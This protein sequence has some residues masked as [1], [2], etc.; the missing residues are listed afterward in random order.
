MKNIQSF[1]ILIIAFGL[2]LNCDNKT[3]KN[4]NSTE[5]AS[6][7]KDRNIF[8]HYISRGLTKTSENLVPGYIMFPVPNSASTYLINRS[9]EVVHEWKGNYESFQAYLMD[10][11]SIIQ[12]AQDPDYPTFGFGGPYGRIQKLTWDNKMLWD[13]EYATKDQIIHHDFAIL[14]N[15]N[16]LAIAYET[17]SYNDAI[18]N[19]RKPELI[20]ESGPWLEKI[21]EI[22]PQGQS[23]GKIVWEWHVADHLIQDYDE[24]KNNFGNPAEHPELLD[25]NLGDSIP[26]SI[27]QDSLDILKAQGKGGRNL[28]TNNKGADIF[29]FNAINYNEALGQ[30]TFSSPELSEIFIIDHNTSI[31]EA[32]GHNGGKYGKGGDFL[33]RW[34]NPKNYRMGDSLDRKLFYQHDIRW[35]EKEK[36]GKGNLTIFNNNIPMGPDSLNY[37]AI[38]EIKPPIKEDGSYHILPNGRFGPEKLHW[39][40]VAKD[41]ISFYGSFISGAHRMKNGNTF[42]NEGPKGR[43]FEVSPSG[44]I[45]WE[46]HIPFR[47]EIRKLNGDPKNFMQMTFSAFRATFIPV[48]HPGLKGKELNPLDP[49]P[50]VYV[51]PPPKKDKKKKDT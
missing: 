26:P 27:T 10:D 3:T 15:G 21:I 49:Q 13:F 44:E 8:G 29:H 7:K 39:S 48:D 2:L 5:T 6:S 46:Y 34:G 4:Q 16:I 41:T 51:M 23:E 35:V 42:I 11:G 22:E 1:L 24:N 38:Y 20:P 50:K 36:P 25:F 12:G 40:Y 47:G 30:I 45:L 31:K 28:T 32:T 43:L 17:Q 14:P 18:A 33:Y 37:T 9:G 19:G